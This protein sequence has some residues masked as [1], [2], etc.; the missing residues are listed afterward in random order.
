MALALGLAAVYMKDG[1]AIVWDQVPVDLPTIQSSDDVLVVSIRSPYE[2]TT[3]LNC[4]KDPREPDNI[5]AC[6]NERLFESRDMSLYRK[7]E[8]ICNVDVEAEAIDCTKSRALVRRIIWQN[9]KR[10]T[11]AFVLFKNANQ[12]WWADDYFFIEPNT[13]GKQQIMYK[14]MFQED[15]LVDDQ[16]RTVGIVRAGPAIVA[17]SWMSDKD[18]CEIT[19]SAPCLQ[20]I[21]DASDSGLF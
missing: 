10:N 2:W 16:W 20:F 13:D 1:L 6:T 19:D 3:E 5:S 12:P 7:Y 11:R 15:R 8:V 4:G 14:R 18:E 9:W 21:V 17:V